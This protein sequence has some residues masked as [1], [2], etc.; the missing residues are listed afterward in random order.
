MARLTR[1][2]STQR[3][4]PRLGF[5][6]PSRPALLKQ[7]NVRELLTLLRAN[8]PCSR[9]DLVRMSGL[10]APTVSSS[11]DYLER[12]KLVNRLGPGS[13]NGGRRPDMLAF[14]SSYGYVA[15]IDLGGSTIR[16]AL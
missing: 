9:A 7:M 15:G 4:W 8:Q 11:V 14:N 1:P 12:R 13:S 2:L 5:T 6:G 10:S 3:S 16:L